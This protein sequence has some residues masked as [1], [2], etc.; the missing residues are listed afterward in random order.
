[1]AVTAFTNNIK[2]TLVLPSYEGADFSP[3]EECL[4]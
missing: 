4:L 1:M 3:Q 2:H